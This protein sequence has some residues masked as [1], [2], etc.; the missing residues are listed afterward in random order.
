LSFSGRTT[1]VGTFLCPSD[2]AGAKLSAIG[3]GIAGNY[4]LSGGGRAWGN[5]ATATD[6]TGGVPT[7]LFFPQSRVRFADITDGTS[8]TLMSSEIILVPDGI[9]VVSGCSGGT[10]DMRGLYWN[11]VHMGSLFVS[12]RAPNTASGDVVGWSCINNVRAPCSACSLN[13]DV[14]TPRSYHPGGVNAGLADASVRFFSDTTDTTV[15][16]NLGTRN[17]GEVLPSL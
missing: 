6:S 2:P 12:F 9:A 8:G 4:L 16:Q 14:V 17:G 15:F 11:N 3:N 10:V 1:V 5:Q 13:N 7:G